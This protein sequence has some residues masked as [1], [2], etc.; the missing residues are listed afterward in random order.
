MTEKLDQF[1]VHILEELQK[2]ASQSQRALSQK[3]GLSQNACW[4]R[5]QRLQKSGVVRGSTLIID[6]E[7]VGANLVVF[8]MIK[9]RHHSEEWLNRFRTHVSNI[10]DVVDFF[11][12]GG[13]F[14]YMLKI[15]T[16]D[17][18]AYD[19]VYR[20]LI[21]KIDLETVTSFFAMEAIAEQRPIRLSETT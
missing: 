20:R 18:A 14:D 15:I 4:R 16:Q 3:V 6:R 21:E 11:R 17:M 19:E 5:L 2:D 10:P 13:E 9:T 1:D 7:K 12:I 8:A